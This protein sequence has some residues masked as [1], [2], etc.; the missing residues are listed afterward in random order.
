LIYLAVS[1]NAFALPDVKVT[2][3]IVD[4]KGV[5]VEGAS[6]T[7]N[8][9]AGTEGNSDTEKTDSDGLATLSGSSTRFIE[10][11]AGKEGYYP[12]WYQ[13]SYTKFT[14]MKGFRKWQPWNEM[15][16]VELRKIKN[17]R[18]LYIGGFTGGSKDSVVELPGTDKEYAYDLT[19]KDWVVPHG[20]GTHRDFIFKLTRKN[21]GYNE[22]DH[23]FVLIFSNDG[24]GI[25]Q[26]D[27]DPVFGSRL[28][29]PHEA[30]LDG[31]KS[32]LIQ[33][34]AS[35]FDHFIANDFPDDR[36]YFF[37]VRTIKDDKGNIE[38]ALY[39]KIYGNIDFSGK[40]FTMLYYLNPDS[41][42]R[43]LESDY[44]KNL[45]PSKQKYGYTEYPP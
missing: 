43:N 13:K 31:Y 38:S 8:F 14:G 15:L 44:K 23:S 24:D 21:T 34:K 37:R 42:D 30:P 33:R 2:L 41:N 19:A 10:Y 25:Q 7:V 40:L 16:T 29:L 45:F 12:T 18:A 11:G 4:D 27:A 36:N 5:P 39:G 9:K 32:E 6:A 1:S 26:H 3:K 22:Y 35:T 28:R 20:L 17:P